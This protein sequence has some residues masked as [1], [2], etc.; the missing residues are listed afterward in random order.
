M[1]AA[2]EGLASMPPWLG[3]QGGG[4]QETPDCLLSSCLPLLATTTLTTLAPPRSGT[5]GTPKGVVLSHR[6]VVQHAVGTIKGGQGWAEGKLQPMRQRA[7]S[8][9]K[10]GRQRGGR[11]SWAEACLG[12]L[13][14]CQPA[15][16]AAAQA[17]GFSGRRAWPS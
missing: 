7:S 2:A 16:G 15:V 8:S 5:T 11:R 17:V 6:I 3:E 10:G 4:Q 14:A 13:A 12:L 1:L 9:Q